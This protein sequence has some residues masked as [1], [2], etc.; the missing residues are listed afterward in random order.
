VGGIRFFDVLGCGVVDGG[1]LID[2]FGVLI[3][4]QRLACLSIRSVVGVD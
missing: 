4:C 1:F 2:E 3:A